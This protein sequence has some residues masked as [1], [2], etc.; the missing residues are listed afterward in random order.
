MYKK[1]DEF[2]IGITEEIEQSELEKDN[3]VLTGVDDVKRAIRKR[4]RD[5]HKGTYGKVAFVS[6][7]RGMA[8][9]AVLNL[10]AALR[11]GAGLVKGFIP[12]TI[13]NVV[14]SMSIEAITHPFNEEKLYF[15]ELCSE[16]LA[17]GDVVATGSGCANLFK[18]ESILHSLMTE[19]L[20]PLVI[21]AEGINVMDL[22]LLKKHGQ[23]IVLTPHYGEMARLLGTSAGELR[24]NI[25][26][27]AR[28]FSSQYDS[29]LVLKGARTVIACPDG[30]V[31]VNTTGNPGMATAGSG[32]VLTGIIAS[33]I[34]QG[35]EITQALKAAVY[36]HGLSGDMAA[37]ELGE[38]S[39]IAGDLIRYLPHA[40]NEIMK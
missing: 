20:C 23:Q 17:F 29:Y 25:P 35:I 6:G 12:N 27:T 16:V 3:L 5:S 39:L 38:Y 14:E 15:D 7:S 37:A 8:G 40:F 9:A 13:Y 33:F 26:E 10:N 28:S 31:F 4:E 11:S 19:C 34:G 22:K 2:I 1:T 36:I 32:D 21:D 30:R 24:K 18:Y